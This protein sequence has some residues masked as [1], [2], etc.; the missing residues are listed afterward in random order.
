MTRVFASF[1]LSSR[2][3]KASCAYLDDMAARVGQFYLIFFTSFLFDF[4]LCSLVFD[5]GERS[6][7]LLFLKDIYFGEP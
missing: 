6:I 4:I 7:I 5:L 3:C 1:I 2:S